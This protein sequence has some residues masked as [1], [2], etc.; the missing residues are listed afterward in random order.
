[1][2]DIFWDPIENDQLKFTFTGNEEIKINIDDSDGATI[3]PG[4]DWSGTEKVTFT[5]SD[6]QASVSDALII[7][8]DTRNDPPIL[9]QTPMKRVYENQLM[10]LIC[11][12]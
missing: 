7:I 6:G 3:S 11:Q 4:T 10:R 9:N 8:I 5:A 12:M 2:N 1:M